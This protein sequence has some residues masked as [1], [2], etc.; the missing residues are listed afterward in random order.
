ML[1]VPAIDLIGG[2][3]VRLYQG[4]YRQQTVYS[5]DPVEVALK[6]QSLRFQR[7]HLVDLEGARAGE[8]V[9][10]KAIREI[11]KAVRIPVEIGG[12]V[13]TPEDVRQLLDCGVSYLIL[14]TVALKAPETVR[15]WVNEWGPNPF[16]ISLDTRGGK[17]QSQGWLE[18]S[19]VTLEEMLDRIEDWGIRQVISTDVE[20]DGT[21]EHPNYAACASL[22]AGLPQDTRLLAAGGVSSLEHI[23]RLRE[24][25]VNGAV[26]GRA[27]Y[28]GKFSL[29]EL[30]R[31]V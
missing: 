16:I 23:A 10:R 11:V 2:K 9:N 7:L 8:G 5:E 17:L 6:F 24:V 25:G 21:L 31:V 26:I 22:L 27:I 30:A 19:P 3:C 15:E 18:E 29:E 12:G 20:R 14:G 4:D 13:R 28:E 1:V